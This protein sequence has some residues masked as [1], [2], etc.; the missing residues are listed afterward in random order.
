MLG[1][2]KVKK[3]E[4]SHL[5]LSREVFVFWISR[6]RPWSVLSAVER[7]DLT[8]KEVGEQKNLQL[9]LKV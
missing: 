4:L 8:V 5:E 7:L 3:V 6:S 1:L 2:F 9:K